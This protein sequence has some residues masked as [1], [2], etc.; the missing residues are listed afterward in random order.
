MRSE[1]KFTKAIAAGTVGF[2]DRL[3]AKISGHVSAQPA[4]AQES[5]TSYATVSRH[6]QMIH[7]SSNGNLVNPGSSQG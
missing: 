1:R 2:G 6:I 3:R 4:L 5:H 7:V